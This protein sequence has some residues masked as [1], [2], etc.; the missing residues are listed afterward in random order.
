MS[1]FSFCQPGITLP[2]QPKMGVIASH[3]K[4]KC[5]LCGSTFPLVHPWGV[6]PQSMEPESSILSIELWVPMFLLDKSNNIFVAT[7]IFFD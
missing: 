4:K 6:E 2:L 5:Y 1:L 3:N 7:Q